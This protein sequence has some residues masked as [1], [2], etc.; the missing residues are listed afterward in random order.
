ML[1]KKHIKAQRFY[2][3][4][5]IMCNNIEDNCYLTKSFGQVLDFI[6]LDNQYINLRFC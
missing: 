1:Y 2:L 6:Y 3:K 4:F 5:Q